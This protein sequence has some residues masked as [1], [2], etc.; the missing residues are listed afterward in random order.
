MNQA[1]REAIIAYGGATVLDV[2][3][4]NGSYVREFDT[5]RT[6]IGL[7]S[8]RF[9]S[10]NQSHR[11]VLSDAVRLPIHDASVSTVTCFETL[12]HLPDPLGALREYARVT[13]GSLILTVPN[14]TTTPGMDASNLI[15]RHF[16]DRT[17]VNFFN[18]ESITALVRE[19]GF[20]IVHVRL[21]NEIDV[22]PLVGEVFRL[23]ALWIR[24][25]RKLLHRY[26]RRYP[27]TCLVVA[28]PR[29]FADSEG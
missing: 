13:H 9:P 7:D 12:E 10:W 14:C 20:E 24:V 17:H 4:G 19:A 18:V 26:A 15:Y 16:V 3:C 27:M 5:E 6:T 2:G 8:H 23:P 25:L 1:R 29:R 21:I 28:Q 11:F 22:F